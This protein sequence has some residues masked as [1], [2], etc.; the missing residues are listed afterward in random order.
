MR[1]TQE[2]R[3]NET[4]AAI[5]DATI[6]CLL[7]QGYSRMSTNEVCE[8]AGYS[9]GALLHYFPTK[10][11]LVIDAI[12]Y[13]VLRMGEQNLSHA[14]AMGS[15]S[16]PLESMFDVIWANFEQPLFHA[17]LELWIAARTDPELY[18]S[19]ARAE[20][21]RGSGIR[22]LYAS[23]AGADSRHPG[24][25]DVLQ[26]TLHLMRGMALQRIL[27][28]DDAHRRKLYAVWR[29]IVAHH[30]SQPVASGGAQSQPT[31]GGHSQ[32]SPISEDPEGSAP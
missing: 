14:K 19:L 27:R 11:A 21:S 9:R 29:Q 7:E 24:F 1:R 31:T 15:S 20:R 30:L 22:E 23:L 2:Q 8:R 17:A 5:L 13:L 3:R 4:R 6:A 25:V 28:P 10:H 12:E 16:S 32:A 18:E 26:L